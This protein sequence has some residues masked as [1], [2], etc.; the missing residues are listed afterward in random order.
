[1]VSKQKYKQYQWMWIFILAVLVVW[2][3]CFVWL[4]RVSARASSEAVTEMSTIY[5]QELS[6]QK[7]GHLKTRISGQLS[8]LEMVGE[9]L[10]EEDLENEQTLTAFLQRMQTANSFD[11]LAFVDDQGNYHSA[12]GTYP[13]ASQISS[14]GALLAGEQLISYD[15]TISGDDMLLLGVDITPVTYGD[16]TLFAVIAGLNTENIAQQLSISTGSAQVQSCIYTQAGN[17][18]VDGGEGETISLGTNLFSGLRQYAEFADGYDL[19]TVRQHF[20]MGRE[21]LCIY[22]VDGEVDYLFYAPIADTDW[23]MTT[24]IPYASIAQTIENFGDTV[25]QNA[26]VVLLTVVAA[27]SV[28]FLSYYSSMRRAN[29][30]T[31]EAMLQAEDANHAK[32]QFL[33]RMSHDIRTP[34][35]GIMGMTNIAMQH[36][37]DQERV[38]DCL[39]KIDVSS[40]H[41]LSLVNDVL[42]LSRIESGHVDVNSAPMDMDRLVNICAEIIEGQLV[43]RKVE[44]VRQF[45]QLNHPHILGD[46]V[47]LKQI[48]IN[49][50]G[51][52][53]KFTPDGG[54]IYFR[55][56]ETKVQEDSLWYHFEVED[57][58]IGMKEE[59][60]DKIWDAFVQEHSGGRT[61]YNGTGLGMTIV[62]Q[63]VDMM[64]G[65]VSVRSQLGVGSCFTV[66]IPFPILDGE[67]NH[68]LPADEQE[69][70]SL[71]GMRVL[72]V[73]D[74]ELNAEIAQTLMEDEGISVTLAENGKAALETFEREPPHRFDVILMDV[75]M[76]VM[77]GLEATRAIRALPR[78]DAQTIP[79]LAMTANAYTEDIQHTTEAGM[80]DHL[81]KP[82]DIGQFMK[83]LARY[84]NKK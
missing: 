7:I 15:E 67:D 47:H 14:M 83:T 70:V 43:D 74:N 2:L 12:E 48:L 79:I 19:D 63:F 62:K 4:Q 20:Q 40:R 25:Y 54:V 60:L 17:L 1:M 55:V 41:L 44:L 65:T 26:V 5:L 28:I 23:Y 75:M 30:A 82:L 52:A 27:L 76:P 57:T 10:S 69:T 3:T 13:V 84:Y 39:S 38:Q 8:R 34:I 29:N 77:D 6:T 9:A 32:S 68:T 36:T 21:G 58:G 45:E 42:D 81:S 37:D 46:E 53:V 33:S 78:P 51:N 18:V 73:E 22:T 66:E 80:N 24:M 11:F 64:G 31:R 59:F 16:G 56:W 50:L 49:I 71:E 72:L 35:N 61:H